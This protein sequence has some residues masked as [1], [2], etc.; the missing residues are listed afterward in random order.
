MDDSKTYLFEIHGGLDI[1][2]TLIPTHS[3]DGQV[4]GFET[5]DTDTARIVRLAMTLEVEY[6]DG[7]IE[8]ITNT[9]DM[10]DLGFRNLDYSKLEFYEGNSEDQETL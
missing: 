10:E 7:R 4:I 9:S 6:P 1:D 8:Y 3:H 5:N 2:A